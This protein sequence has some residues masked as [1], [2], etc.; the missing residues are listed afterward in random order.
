[1]YEPVEYEN[2][3]I[4]TIKVIGIGG[5]GSNAVEY[6][7]KD[8]VDGTEFYV[9]NTDAQAL[10]KSTVMHSIQIGLEATKGLGA[11]ANP[12]VG[13][14][15]AEDDKEAIK[16]ML[17]GADMVFI[18][19]G[20]GGGT[21]TGAAPVIAKIAKSL[22][23]LTV[24]VITK[25]FNFEGKKRMRVAEQGLA[26][27]VTCVDSLIVIPNEK[28]IQILPKNI[29]LLD[30]F[31]EANDVLRNAVRGVSDIITSHGNINVDFSDVRTVMS[32]MGY[33]MMG[34][35]IAS[36]EPGDG[37]AEKAAS[38]AINSPLLEDIDLS[39]G[40]R[41]VLVNITAGENINLAEYSAI[42]DLIQEFASDEAVI[43]IG[44]S[45]D[46]ALKEEIKVTVVATGIASIDAKKRAVVQPAQ[47]PRPQQPTS[48]RPG[49][50]Q[51]PV[52]PQPKTP[53]VSHR[54][55]KD[56]IFDIDGYLKNT[57]VTK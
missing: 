6:M 4:P 10:R 21:G 16:N 30:A 14:K 17:T 38:M 34:I 28:L 3:I 56:A 25:P 55:V 46:P 20:M 50:G 52:Q 37:R 23:I 54:E 27:L 57:K 29:G 36:G 35:G 33:A 53:P 2:E 41:G 12:E 44:T 47:Q 8:A 22:G 32:E 9:I 49:Q 43:V 7:A 1:M 40:A 26:E 48:R 31:A 13:R 19:T 45:I 11:G 24:A 51:D 5:G 15:A 39:N 18:A 42:G